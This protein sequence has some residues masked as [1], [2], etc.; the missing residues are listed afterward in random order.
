MT[1]DEALSALLY[2]RS[3]RE[4]FAR[5]E[6]SGLSDD[7]V[8]ALS[9][10]DLDELE[11]AARLACGAL[12]ERPHRGVGTLLDA[13]PQTIGAWTRAHPERSSGDLAMELA[14]APAFD[15]YSAVQA[16]NGISLEEAFFRFAEDRAIGEPDVRLCEFVTAIVK[17]LVVTPRPFFALPDIVRVA[18]RGHFAVLEHGPTLIAA[19]EGRLV[20]GPITR[21]LAAVLSHPESLDE[22][23]M[24]FGVTRADAL[25][26]RAE[27]RTMGL[28]V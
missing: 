9:T 7:D 22:L 15:A 2:R 20:V 6:R 16:C 24:R 12:L 13:F 10:L 26:A 3:F 4:R 19:L 11:R 17:S 21:F 28:S 18:P 23:A 25:A 5:G 1:L 8:R 14:D 27:L